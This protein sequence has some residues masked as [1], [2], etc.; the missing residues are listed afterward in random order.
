M[1]KF[2]N[3]EHI[4][5][6]LNLIPDSEVDTKKASKVLSMSNNEVLVASQKGCTEWCSTIR[7]VLGSR[8]IRGHVQSSECAVMDLAREI[9]SLDFPGNAELRFDASE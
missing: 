5:G 8:V 9:A 4:V 1:R 6:S 3:G 2:A 7:G